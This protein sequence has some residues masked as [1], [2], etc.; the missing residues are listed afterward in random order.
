[1][2]IFNSSIE[3]EEETG[4]PLVHIHETSLTRAESHRLSQAQLWETIGRE[5]LT[6]SI[7]DKKVKYLAFL[8]STRYHNPRRI[9]PL[10][11]SV[12]LQLTRGHIAL[13][14]G[15][16]ALF[17]TGCLW[18]WPSTIATVQSRLVDPTPVDPAV[19]M[20][21][22]GYRG[23]VGGCVATSLG[24]VLHELG[25]AWDLGHTQQGI[26]ARGFD[27][28]DS[29]LTVISER[30]GSLA[31]RP[32][33]PCGN[34]SRGGSPGLTGQTISS[35]SQPARFTAVKRS[36]SVS[37]YLESY[38]EARLETRL[39]EERGEGGCYWTPSC[40]L[41]LSHQPWLRPPE[42]TLS[43]DGEIAVSGLQVEACCLL[44][45]VELRGRR[46]LVE[47]TWDLS[48]SS[49]Q[50]LLLEQ[51]LIQEARRNCQEDQACQLVAM[52]VCGRLRKVSLS[53]L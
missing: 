38:S 3:S 46:G 43:C 23:T 20:D 41:L 16:L 6:S 42:V 51:E 53:Q 5:L 19:S 24:S 25:H 7:G 37:K 21:D 9:K 18:T 36:E 13:G 29:L 30:G 33:T 40:A 4:E 50:S 15:G 12:T 52:A 28:L 49:S 45:L 11:H 44:A 34:L 27:D 10:S 26:M 32:R 1:M 14:G 2:S 35:C 39:E 31:G 17:G 8:S 48:V 47:Q 22:S